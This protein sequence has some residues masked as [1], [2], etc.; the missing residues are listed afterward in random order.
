MGTGTTGDLLSVQNVRASYRLGSGKELRAVDGVSL[1]LREGEVLGVVGE[2]GCGKS[3]LA[4]ILALNAAP[5]LYVESGTVELQ[6][7]RADL[8]EREALP[9]SERGK[10]ISVLPQS[11]MNSINPTTRVRDLAYDVLR[12]HE[13]ISRKAAW[14]AGGGE[15]RATRSADPRLGALPA[16]TLRRNAPTRD[17]RYFDA[18]RPQNPDRRRTD[19][20]VRRFVAARRHRDASRPLGTQNHLGCPLYHPRLAAFAPHRRPGCGDV[21]RQNCR[22]RPHGAGYQRT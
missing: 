17:Y 12:A 5:P 7:R 6:G 15:A 9:R 18:A 19:L 4:T 16:R 13:R 3:T 1:E 14:G 10:L 21:R 8:T 20:G 11:A 2:S 22:T